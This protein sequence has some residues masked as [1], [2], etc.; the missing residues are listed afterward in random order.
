LTHQIGLNPIFFEVETDG[1]LASPF[2]IKKLHIMG[3]PF[4]HE[5]EMRKERLGSLWPLQIGL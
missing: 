2:G 5:G 3:C 4:K 1:R